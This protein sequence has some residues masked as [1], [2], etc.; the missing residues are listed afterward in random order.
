MQTIFRLFP[1]T[2]QL[3]RGLIVIH[4]VLMFNMSDNN[5]HN[6]LLQFDIL[7]GTIFYVI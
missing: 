6:W 7:Y 4:I 5:I 2:V 1:L 3:Q